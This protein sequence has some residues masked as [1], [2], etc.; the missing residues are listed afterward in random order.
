MGSYLEIIEQHDKLIVTAGENGGELGGSETPERPPAVSKHALF[1]EPGG[2][3][4]RQRTDEADFPWTVQ[5]NLSGPGLSDELQ[6]ML[7]MF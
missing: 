2:E 7:M 3:R 4:K 5:E 6:R 1:P